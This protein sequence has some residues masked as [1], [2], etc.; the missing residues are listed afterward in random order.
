MTQT[1]LSGHTPMMRQYL[2]LKAEAGPLLLL[3]RMGDFYELF[4]EDAEK[5]ARL[6]NLTLTTRGLSNGKPVRMAGV[7]FPSVEGYLARLVAL[8]ESVPI[9]EQ[10]GEVG[11]SKGPV[12]RQI[13]R[14]VTPG[15]LTDDALLPAKADRLIAALNPVVRRRQLR[16]GLAWLNLANGEFR[17]SEC[18]PDELASELHRIDPAE[19]LLAE[20][21]QL[22]ADCG[23]LRATLST[24]PDWHF[25][26][27][28][29][30]A[31]LTEHFGVD[32]LD[33]F[34]VT[35]MPL[36]VAAAGALLRYVHHTQSQAL[37]HVRSLLADRPAQ[38]V[39]LDPATRRNLELTETLRGEASPTLFSV[40]DHCATPMGS[41][42]LRRWLH[43]PLR[44]NQVLQQRQHAIAT[45]L[46]H[47]PDPLAQ[48]L[49]PLPDLERMASRLALRSIRP[50]ELAS[51]RDA[52]V[53]LPEVVSCLRAMRHGEALPLPAAEA[54]LQNL[55]DNLE[56]DP[57]LAA[58]LQQAIAQEPSVAL[59]DGGVM[60][61]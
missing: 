57:A 51:L 2:Q 24:C 13:V 60:A 7:L 33:G 61:D 46:S 20:S 12:E 50:R 53:Q 31:Q 35:D 8:G 47:G 9:C 38:Y 11:A 52:L 3:Y 59:R 36:A 18:H 58:L 10:V 41:R 19:L 16:Y 55:A 14:I 15:T 56:V 30:R 17:L 23:E 45:L 22:P 5:A 21:Q 25:E 29:A 40:L 34:D 54:A 44:D 49:A 48:L 32:T 39:W 4:Y 28:G 26:S 42:L 37:V 6:L 1:D 27:E 43:H